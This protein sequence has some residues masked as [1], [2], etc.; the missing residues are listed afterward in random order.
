M[1]KSSLIIFL[2]FTVII[3]IGVVEFI[4]LKH[5]S[6]ELTQIIDMINME[7]DFDRKNEMVA[8]F[9]EKWEKHQ[10]ILSVLVDHQD[11][12]KI[13]SVLVENEVILKNNLNISQISTN[14]ATLKLYIKDIVEERQFNIKNVL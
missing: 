2:G 7:Q 13:E 11:I 4:Y 3:G 10:K 6:E 12:H 14:F 5:M 1:K 8:E 9:R